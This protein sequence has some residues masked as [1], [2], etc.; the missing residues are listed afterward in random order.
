VR[1]KILVYSFFLIENEEC[2]VNYKLVSHCLPVLT[3]VEPKVLFPGEACSPSSTTEICG[4][5]PRVF[6][7]QNIVLNFYR[8]DEGNGICVGVSLYGACKR[9][10]DCN[11]G[12]FCN[13]GHCVRELSI[14][15]RIQGIK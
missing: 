7:L 1:V 4:F 10:A 15:I 5:G 3:F 13:Y 2:Y 12:L 11:Y 9:T 6:V 14:V 8:C